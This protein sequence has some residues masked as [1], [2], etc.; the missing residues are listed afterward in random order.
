[1]LVYY[2]CIQN[3]ILVANLGTSLPMTL[4][5]YYATYVKIVNVQTYK[6]NSYDSVP[7]QYPSLCHKKSITEKNM[8]LLLHTHTTTI[9]IFSLS[10]YQYAIPTFLVPRFYQL[11]RTY[12]SYYNMSSFISLIQTFCLYIIFLIPYRTLLPNICP[13]NL[14]IL[15]FHLPYY[16]I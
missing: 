8:F 11:F 6:I 3:H 16:Q 7:Y 14:I 12:H 9:L 5:H 2:I 4:L 1:M 13:R 10:F 15:I